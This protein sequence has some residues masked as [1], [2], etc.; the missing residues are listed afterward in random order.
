LQAVAATNELKN[1][2]LVESLF[3]AWNRGEIDAFAGHMAEDVAWLEVAGRPEAEDSELLGRDRMRQSLASLFEAW[4]SYRVELERIDDLGDRVVAVV[5]EVARGR[6]S[7][8]EVDG[9]WGYLITVEE[10]QIVR[11]EAYRHAAMAL[12]AAGLGESDSDA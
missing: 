5:R 11:I 1:V 7:G 2:E 12:Q 10:G 6:A 3:D 4:E 9:R 8:V